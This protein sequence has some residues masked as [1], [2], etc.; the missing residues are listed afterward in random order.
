MDSCGLRWNNIAKRK[1]SGVKWANLKDKV[2]FMLSVLYHT[3]YVL[4]SII[5]NANS[6]CCLSASKTRSK[7]NI[8]QQR[9]KTAAIAEYARL[10]HTCWFAALTHVVGICRSCVMILHTYTQTLL[11]IHTLTHLLKHIHT[12]LLLEWQK[13]RTHFICIRNKNLI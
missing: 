1:C 10:P 12:Y 9:M 2:L 6:G 13:S 5:L 4:N 7:N 3:T 11:V 8:Y